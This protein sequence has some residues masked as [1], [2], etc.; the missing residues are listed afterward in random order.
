MENQIKQLKELVII[1]YNS[2]IKEKDKREEF[3]QKVQQIETTVIN[4]EL[5]V[6]EEEQ[7]TQQKKHK[8]TET[9]NVQEETD[10]IRKTYI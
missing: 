9:I 1:L 10:K 8:E 3:L 5:D 7:P 4:E 6:V 2:M